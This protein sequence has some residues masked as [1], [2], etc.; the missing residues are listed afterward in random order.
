MVFSIDVMLSV[1]I[2]CYFVFVT[3]FQGAAQRQTLSTLVPIAYRSSAVTVFT[4]IPWPPLGTGAAG[5]RPIHNSVRPP[6]PM[7]PAVRV[8]SRSACVPPHR[9]AL[10]AVAALLS[11]SVVPAD[12]CVDGHDPRLPSLCL[13]PLYP[14]RGAS[15]ALC[16]H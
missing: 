15:A 10:S 2:F 14:S 13:S 3:A 9:L 7:Y 6:P 16:R 5:L 11:V 4:A 12:V 8:P 1:L